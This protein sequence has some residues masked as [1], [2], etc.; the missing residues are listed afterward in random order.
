MV[1]SRDIIKSIAMISMILDHTFS[2]LVPELKLF[3]VFGEA[4]APLYF[5]AAGFQDGKK[6]YFKYLFGG[7]FLTSLNFIFKHKL[8]FNILVSFFII[9]ILALFY[10]KIP[11]RWHIVFHFTLLLLCSTQ[12]YVYE[13]LEYGIIG[14]FLGTAFFYHKE[15]LVFSKFFA[16]LGV[17]LHMYS[18]IS[19]YG[20]TYKLILYPN[21]VYD[22]FF[23]VSLFV[24]YL[25]CIVIILCYR[26]HN[27]YFQNSSAKLI[28]FIS[29]KSFWIYIIHLST[30][31]ILRYTILK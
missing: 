7:L 31:I 16:I 20:R 25:T 18:N 17:L 10:F 3:R 2:Y 23:L 26:K 27:F 11:K 30:F 15:N 5:F 6:I 8:H 22:I 13:T 1:N 19:F 29:R 14:I 28:K 21:S 24:V 12:I 9:N 4:A